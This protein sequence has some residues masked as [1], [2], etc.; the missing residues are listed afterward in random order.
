[1]TYDP[2]LWGMLELE[3]PTLPGQFIV[4]CGEARGP[5]WFGSEWKGRGEAVSGQRWRC[6]LT[7]PHECSIERRSFQRSSVR[8]ISALNP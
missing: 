1:M 5:A 8:I 4:L 7:V 6:C 3:L 2:L